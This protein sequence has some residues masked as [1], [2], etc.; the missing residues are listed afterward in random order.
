MRALSVRQP[1]AELIARGAKKV[2]HRSWTRSFRGDLLIV[3]SG[4]RHDDECTDERLDPDKLAYGAAVCVV[5]LWK[6][7]GDEGDYS[8]H[9]RNPRRVEPVDVK[10]YA[11]IYHVD[12][13]LIHFAKS[14]PRTA[15]VRAKAKKSAAVAR[16][17]GAPSVLIAARD[18]RLA[19]RWQQALRSMGCRVTALRCLA[20]PRF[21][22][23]SLRTPG[24][25]RRRLLGWRS[26]RADARERGARR[27]AGD[28]RGRGTSAS[29]GRRAPRPSRRLSSERSCK[30]RPDLV[31][32]TGGPHTNRALSDS[33]WRTL[34]SP[35][36]STCSPSGS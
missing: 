16:V 6:V 18:P 9:V 5:E 4:S 14:S 21:T 11:S 28:R 12:D 7:S 36:F 27:H 13:A 24:R 30:E 19:R 10:G 2:E 20:P 1:W 35:R 3:A 31:H 26:A 33:P 17:A 22:L 8:W 32:A 34:P 15:D 29:C 25:R 23:R